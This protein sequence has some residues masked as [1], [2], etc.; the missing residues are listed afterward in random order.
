MVKFEVV[1]FNLSA[2]KY[3]FEHR[4]SLKSFLNIYKHEQVDESIR[5]PRKR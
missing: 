2:S 5:P 3:C 1:Y 4:S